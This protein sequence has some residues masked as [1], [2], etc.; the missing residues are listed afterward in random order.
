MNGARGKLLN[1]LIHRLRLAHWQKAAERAESMDTPLLRQLRSE[2]R[3]VRRE[4]DRVLET[5]DRRLTLPLIGSNA[6]RRQYNT[7]WVWRPNLWRLPILPVGIAAATSPAD[8]DL[9]T[10][11]HH[12]CKNS[13]VTVRQV[14]NTRASDLAPFGL[15]MDVFRFDGTFMSLSVKLPEAAVTGLH[16]GHLVR[17]DAIIETEKPLEILARLNVRNG[18]NTAQM[19]LELPRDE[20][21][22]SVEFDL[23]Y[24][25]INEKRI[26]KAWIDLFF[27]APDMN[28][29]VLRD[30]SFSRRPRAKM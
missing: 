15:R 26:D 30:I 21:E 18:P 27:E 13:E 17:V 9:E 20:S 12:N 10:S 14:R 29:I 11:L 23:A 4:I 1:R 25:K 24:S 19:V 8:L 16:L 6:T 7:D 28:Q 5:A 22:K 3:Q 2:V